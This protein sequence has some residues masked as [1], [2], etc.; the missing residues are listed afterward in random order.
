[1]NHQDYYFCIK[2]RKM[3]YLLACLL[4][5]AL[6]VSCTGERNKKDSK[7][8][9]NAREIRIEL[10][11]FE[12]EADLQETPCDSLS[13]DSTETYLL[14]D[15]PFTGRCYSTYPNSDKRYMEITYYQGKLHGYF[16]VYDKT[17]NVLSKERYHKGEQLQQK[18]NNAD[19]IV[20]P[21]DS[22]NKEEKT[23]GDGFIY[24]YKEL[25][26]TGV[27]FAYY[28]NTKIKYIET[29][30]KKG[31]PDG[32]NTVFDKQGNIITQEIYQKGEKV[33]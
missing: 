10:G 14:N 26:F 24:R 28:P 33:N 12:N 25:P 21:C 18:H 7:E 20:C 13:K 15:H 32:K 22:L 23:F 5:L 4:L 11:S 2:I 1:M 6:S 27:C 16:T 9:K 3:K 30:Y 8:N 29:E 19:Q 17:G 31:L